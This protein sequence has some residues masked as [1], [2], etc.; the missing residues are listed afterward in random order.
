METTGDTGER[1]AASAR[2]RGV[3]YLVQAVRMH[4]GYGS[5]PRY[6]YHHGFGGLRIG[7]SAQAGERGT[8]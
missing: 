8:A 1:G 6:G 2:E 4:R 3:N 5:V 7:G